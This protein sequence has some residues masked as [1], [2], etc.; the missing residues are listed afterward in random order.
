MHINRNTWTRRHQ[1]PNRS[2]HNNEDS[3]IRRHFYPNRSTYINEHTMTCRHYYPTRSTH[4]VQR[5]TQSSNRSA[6][7]Q[8]LPEYKLIRSKMGI[9][10][11]Q[12]RPHQKN[13]NH[14]LIYNS[15]IQMKNSISKS[16][17]IKQAWIPKCLFT[18]LD[19]TKNL[20]RTK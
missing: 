1:Y 19:T 7:L 15:Q 20:N 12:E 16:I 2:T 18:V 14:E 17:C 4:S 8:N 13:K 6:H 3:L 10:Y 11:Y 5:S 9:S